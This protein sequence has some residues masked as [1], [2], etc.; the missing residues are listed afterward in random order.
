MTKQELKIKLLNTSLF[1]DNNYLQE[2]LNLVDNYITTEDYTE[3]HHILPRCWYKYNKQPVDNSEDNVVNLAYKDHCKAHWLLYFCTKGYL[4]QANETAVR[5]ISEMYKKL[6]G[7]ETHKFDFIQA[8]FELLQAYMNDIIKDK[9]SRYYSLEEEA[10][11]KQ[12]YPEYGLNYCMQFFP[13][14]TEEAVAR[15]ISKLKLKRTNIFWTQEEETFLKENYPKYG[16]NYCMKALNR[17]R[18][19]IKCKANYMGLKVINLKKYN[20]KWTEEEILVLK[21]N[22]EL[23]GLAKCIELLPTHE[24]TAIQKRASML[25]LHYKRGTINGENND[26]REN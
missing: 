7:I 25:G 11:L 18:L 23:Y 10:I 3:K 16:I 5:Y 4:Q 6:T 15:Y 12:Y 2:Y 21:N 9:N 26:R 22:Y 8:D 13:N 20:K 14:R 17:T 1:I 19:M 24:K